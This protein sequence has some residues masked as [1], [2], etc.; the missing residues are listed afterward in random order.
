M[1]CDIFLLSSILP[2]NFCK[3]ES[4]L[5]HVILLLP[6]KNMSP[7]LKILYNSHQ[8]KNV[9][10][11]HLKRPD[12]TLQQLYEMF[13]GLGYKHIIIFDFVLYKGKNIL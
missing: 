11:Y 6:L 12:I 7:S 4:G 9:G 8:K 5:L 10:N 13:A 3:S 2:L 1:V